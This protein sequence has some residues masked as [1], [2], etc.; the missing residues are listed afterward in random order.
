[1]QYYQPIVVILFGLI[2]G[3]FLNVL[4]YRLPRRIQF[5]KGRSACPGCGA[6]IKWY[7]N[8]PLLSFL[9]LRGK[10]AS[11][12][13]RISFVY[14]L[15]EL[16]NGLAYSY[17][18]QTYGWSL[19]FGVFSF[20]ASALIVIFF[21]DLEHQIIPD[22]ITLPGMIIG[23]A[24]AL[25][26]GGIGIV[27]ALIGLAVGGGSLYLIALLGDW[28]FKKE[29][30]GG[31]DIKM[32]AMLGA[33]LGWQKVLFIFMASAVIGLIVSLA[34]M[35][36]SAKLRKTR[37]VPFGPFIAVAAITAVVWGDQLIAYYVDNLLHLN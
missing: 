1:M 24:V 31:G 26:P 11:C 16:L 6:I 30:M 12:G 18:F 32:A 33:F 27:P 19:H 5:A 13:A 2:F 3:S 36:V 25:V 17:F 9:M 10:C 14:P 20:L 23:L 37:L 22:L 21:I 4:I 28:L 7:Q 8:I 15:V 29:S 35:A 34:L